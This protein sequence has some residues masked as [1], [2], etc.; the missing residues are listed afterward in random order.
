MKFCLVPEC[1]YLTVSIIDRFLAKVPIDKDTLQ[2]V[3][4]TSLF[5]AAK[6]EE[7][8][9]PAAKDCVYVTDRAFTKQDI[10]DMELD[11]LDEL[12]FSLT[13]P[14]LYP[15]LLRF[16]FLV[17]ATET[18]TSA[19]SYY[20]ERTLVEH[21]SLMYRPS[22]IA[23]AA[24]CLAISH[25][26]IREADNLREN[27]EGIVRLFIVALFTA[28]LNALLHGLFLAPLQPKVLLDYTGFSPERIKD[29]AEFVATK[30]SE[31]LKFLHGGKNNSAIKNKY[32]N[33]RFKSV[34]TQFQPPDAIDLVAD[35]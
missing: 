23:A 31:T 30:V 33:S 7:I 11:I 17:G 27:S 14:T 32:G 25:P 35:T 34:A 13:V 15:F 29:V 22:E 21:E 10:L 24:V 20:A 19:A 28:Y 1:L 12:K 8:Y 5:V 16:L 26:E 4:I 3:G 18:V 2:L 6:Y 9:P